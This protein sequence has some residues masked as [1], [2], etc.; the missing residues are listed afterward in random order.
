[1]CSNDE[2]NAYASSV[3]ISQANGPDDF[4]VHMN[5][6]GVRHMAELLA[7]NANQYQ[8]LPVNEI[9]PGTFVIIQE[10][11]MYYRAKVVA[12][13]G[14]R[15]EVFAMDYG[16]T[17]EVDEVKKMPGS[18]KDYDGLALHC[19]LEGFENN[20]KNVSSDLRVQFLKL[21]NKKEQYTIEIT[22]ESNADPMVIRLFDENGKNLFHSLEKGNRN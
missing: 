20:R 4:Y 16:W 19:C 1:M 5:S 8:S 14:N 15:Y 12:T 9:K 21:A 11:G 2:I 13:K 10:D 6:I 7:N 3:V 18:L 22:S 17:K